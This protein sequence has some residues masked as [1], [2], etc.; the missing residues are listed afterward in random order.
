MSDKRKS[1]VGRIYVVEPEHIIKKRDLA[2]YKASKQSSANNK[3]PVFV[4]VQRRGKRV[5][6]SSM[7]SK[8][9][10]TDISKGYRLKLERTYPNRE[11]YVK[12][13]S[14]GKS[15]KTGMNFRIDKDPLTRSNLKIQ[16]NQEDIV[17]HQQARLKMLKRRKYKKK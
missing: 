6:V 3:R 14:I 7:T 16:A 17:K 13:E 5:Q 12:T 9:R 10:L 2:N 11:S 15:R 8:A 4:S 1:Y